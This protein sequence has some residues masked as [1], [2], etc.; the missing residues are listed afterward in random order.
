MKKTNNSRANLDILSLLPALFL[1]LMFS[2][3]ENEIVAPADKDSPTVMYGNEERGGE[4][5]RQG[6]Q[7][8]FT[9]RLTGDQELAEV[10]TDGSGQAILKLSKDGLSLS[11][12]IVVNNVDNITQAHIHCGGPEDNGPVVAFLFGFIDGGVTQN[13]VLTEGTITAADVIAR[14]D[15]E[16][17]MGGVAS[18]AQLVEKL[19]SG[20]AYVNVHTVD[21]P[22]GE[23][24][25]QIR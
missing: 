8:T 11:Y 6:V 5:A 18:F 16:E 10:E 4:N 9:A 25:G 24:R 15:S 7:R 19:K 12:K 13:G 20:L 14:P 22:G 17:C 3:A 21:Y 2:C 1:L 23:I